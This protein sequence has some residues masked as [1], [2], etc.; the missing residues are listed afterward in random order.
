V[1]SDEPPLMRHFFLDWFKTGI[2]KFWIEGASRATTGRRQRARDQVVHTRTARS[3]VLVRS[4]LQAISFRNV[5][6]IFAPQAHH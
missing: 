1:L 2:H 3:L 4:L 6:F 5:A